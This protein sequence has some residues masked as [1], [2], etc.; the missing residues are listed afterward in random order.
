MNEG[1]AKA[2]MKSAGEANKQMKQEEIDRLVAAKLITADEYKVLVGTKAKKVTSLSREENVAIERYL[3]ESFY[4][5][6]ITEALIKKDNNGKLRTQVQTFERF[7]FPD[8]ALRGDDWEV[9]IFLNNL[10]DERANYTIGT[11]QMNWAASSVQDGRDHFQKR[12]T[13]RPRE[14]GIRFMKR[15]GD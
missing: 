6:D 15:W 3:L 12:Y 9:S 14:L 1:A 4:L 5:Q 11:D 10:T 2:G 13:N 8:S 7:M